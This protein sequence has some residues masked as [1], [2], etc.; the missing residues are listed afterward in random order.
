MGFW[1]RKQILSTTKNGIKISSTGSFLRKRQ[2]WK[3]KFEQN[4]KY[5]QQ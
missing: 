1:L 3:A 5:K 4:F 2:Q